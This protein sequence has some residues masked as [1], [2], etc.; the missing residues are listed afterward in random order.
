MKQNYCAFCAAKLTDDVCE[1]CGKSITDYHAAPHWLLPGTVLGG[2]YE[3]GAVL[4]EGGFGITYIGHDN[5]LDV[6]VAIKEY[7]PSG[8]VNRN[9]TSSMEIS[10]LVGDTQANFEKGK[11]GFL[12]EARTLAK[13]SNEQSIVSVRD[14]FEENNTAYIVMEYLEGTDLKDYIH[15]KGKV[16]FQE[17]LKMLSPIM[18]SLSK[19]HNQGLIHRDISPANIMILKDGFVKLLDFG[20]A[21]NVSGTDEKSLSVLLKPGFAPEE[22]YRSK[23]NQGAWTDVYALSA[24]LYKMV[25]GV[26]PDDAMNR[27]FSDEVVSPTELNEQV[28]PEQSAVILKGMS[29]YQKDRYQTVEELQKACNDALESKNNNAV[30]THTEPIEKTISKKSAQN[31]AVEKTINKKYSAVQPTSADIR[32]PV[33]EKIE[34]PVSNPISQTPQQTNNKKAPKIWGLIG[35]IVA[36]LI[37]LFNVSFLISDM[38]DPTLQTGDYVKYI[39]EIVIFAAITIGCGY[40]YYPRVDKANLKPNKIALIASVVLTVVALILAFIGFVAFGSDLASN[41]DGEA[42]MAFAVL[43]A[44]TALYLG[45]FYYP[46]LEKKVR[47]KFFKVYGSAFA[48]IVVCFVLYTVFVTM[49]TVSI[50]DEK[51]KK[52]AE[53]VEINADLLTDG[54]IEKLSQLKNLKEL[55]LQ[56]CLLDDNDVAIIGNMTGLEK[57]SLVGNTDIKDI[58]P[59]SNLTSLTFLNLELTGTVDVSC[60]SKL[61]N[62]THLS[63]SESKVKDVSVVKDLSKLEVFYMNNL[64]NLDETTIKVPMGLI[65]FYCNNNGLTNIEFLRENIALNR[66][67][68][69]GNKITDIS[70]L[71]TKPLSMVNVSGNQITDISPI[72]VTNFELKATDNQIS[73]ISCLKNT[74]AEFIFLSNNKISDISAFEAND[75]L[76]TL[77]LKNNNIIDISALKDC[78][79]ISTLDLSENQITDISALATIDCLNNLDMRDN[80][81]SDITPLAQN[82]KFAES[83][84]T[85]YL[86][87][88]KIVDLT[89]LSNFKNSDSIWLDDN[90]IEDVSPLASCTMLEHLSIKNN[91][92]SDLSALG[93]MANLNRVFAIGNPIVKIDGLNLSSER[94]GLSGEK[95]S[96]DSL[97]GGSILSLSYTEQI[98]WAA[99]KSLRI[100]DLRV[101]D[102]PARQRAAM[103]D[104]GYRTDYDSSKQEETNE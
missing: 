86:S 81:I 76:R 63:I 57:L 39:I 14:F 50:G 32:Q 84:P 15:Q 11:Q 8:V 47:S 10:A 60:L 55:S 78:F 69:S 70:P 64:E 72:A 24:T 88:N 25:T 65:E 59:L 62:L 79:N 98:D 19:I 30:N 1:Y 45:Y 96:S 103:D 82:Q 99:A 52:N 97:L 26:T 61:T 37:A 83:G 40:F 29:I 34:T 102:I 101:Y 41:G 13:F 33:A 5:V 38:A 89:P 56:A 16:S 31:T 17:A 53:T 94:T 3:V 71:S 100:D 90:L 58:T 87:N 73:D 36:G 54:D 43:F 6:K 46:R 95:Y 2:K 66:V 49:S 85:I 22:Q 42:F 75:G 23:G 51:I 77:E 18:S 68:L 44:G 12:S 21:R 67:E 9:N 48:A 35:S 104:L 80:Q 74:K 27:L 7:F 28:T 4:G 92:I 93:D 20:A 91:R